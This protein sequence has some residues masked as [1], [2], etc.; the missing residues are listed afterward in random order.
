MSPPLHQSIKKNSGVFISAQ[1]RSSTFERRFSLVGKVTI[2]R[3]LSVVV[4]NRQYTRRKISSSKETSSR[5][6]A[7]SRAGV[8]VSSASFLLSAGEF[9]K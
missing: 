9:I 6:L 8:A 2:S 3:V 7:A 1:N 4:G 5:S